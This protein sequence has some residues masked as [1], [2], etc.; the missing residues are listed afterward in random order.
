[1]DTTKT[2]TNQLDQVD[3]VA[4]DFKNAVLVVSLIAN[5]TVFTGWLTITLA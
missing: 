1:M 3:T 4:Q 5:L 2:N